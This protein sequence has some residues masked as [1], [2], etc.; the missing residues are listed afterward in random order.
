MP[1]TSHPGTGCQ[2][3]EL[4]S[5]CSVFFNPYTVQVFLPRDEFP[6]AFLSPGCTVPAL[7]SC[8]G[9]KPPLNH[10]HHL[11]LGPFP[12]SQA[13]QHPQRAALVLSWGKGSPFSPLTPTVIT[14]PNATQDALAL[15]YRD[16][17]VGHLLLVLQDPCG[18]FCKEPFS[19]PQPACAVG[20]FLTQEE[21]CTAWCCFLQLDAGLQ[22]TGE[23]FQL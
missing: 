20:L 10:S 8:P 12:N 11:E 4:D 3:E 5:V 14:S 18:L 15:L 22:D 7:S 23:F 21:P 19:Q 13:S 9:M 16:T 17:L 2:W 6:W 1:P